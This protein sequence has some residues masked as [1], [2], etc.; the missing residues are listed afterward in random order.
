MEGREVIVEYYIWWREFSC[1]KGDKEGIAMNWIL[2]C[3]SL[4]LLY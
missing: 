2:L 3:F 4:I 1:K